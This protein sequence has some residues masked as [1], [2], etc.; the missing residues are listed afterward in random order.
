LLHKRLIEKDGLSYS[1]NGTKVS[2]HILDSVR[3]AVH[4]STYHSKYRRNTWK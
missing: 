4:Y 3:H 2:D 1:I